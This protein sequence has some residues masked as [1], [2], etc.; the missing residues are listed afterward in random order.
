MDD[1]NRINKSRK[2]DRIVEVG[3]HLAMLGQRDSNNSLEAAEKNTA[4]IT[5][6]R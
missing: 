2:Q 3:S 4:G 1:N 5:R 6:R